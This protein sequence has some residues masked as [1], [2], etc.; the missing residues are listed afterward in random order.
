MNYEDRV[1]KEY[2]ENALANAGPKIATGT[3]YGTGEYGAATP[4]RIDCGFAPKL[5]W[6]IPDGAVSLSGTFIRPASSAVTRYDGVS[7]AYLYWSNAGVSWYSNQRAE[8]QLNS[9]GTTYYWLA[10]G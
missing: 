4:N 8:G 7:F 10:I 3:Y 5:V 1:T 6:V 2:L 9:G